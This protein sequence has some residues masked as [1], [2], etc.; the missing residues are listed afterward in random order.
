MRGTA[1]DVCCGFLR[2]AP[3]ANQFGQIPPLCC[4]PVPVP[5]V[6]AVILP[7][8]YVAT[9]MPFTIFFLDNTHNDAW[10][11]VGEKPCPRA[12]QLHRAALSL[13]KAI[14]LACAVCC[15]LWHGGY[16]QK[17]PSPLL[18]RWT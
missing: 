5:F 12:R 3:R 6:C 2:L 13:R 16:V 7:L 1:P 4:M 11:I 18:L 17:C 14:T 15:T 9:I 8:L 10:F